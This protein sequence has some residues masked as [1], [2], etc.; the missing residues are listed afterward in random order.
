MLCNLIRVLLVYIIQ[1][2]MDP[3]FYGNT[4]GSYPAEQISGL[5]YI[6]SS[7]RTSRTDFFKFSGNDAH[8]LL[9]WHPGQVFRLCTFFTERYRTSTLLLSNIYHSETL[10]Q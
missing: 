3:I 10:L 4:D 7:Q 8:I 1:A 5:L 2:S 9:A 6:F